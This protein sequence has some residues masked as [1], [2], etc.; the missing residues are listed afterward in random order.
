MYNLW[1]MYIRSS[2][3]NKATNRGLISVYHSRP[4]VHWNLGHVAWDQEPQYKDDVTSRGSEILRIVF[5][6]INHALVVCVIH[7]INPL[8]I[9]YTLEMYCEAIKIFKRYGKTLMFMGRSKIDTIPLP[10]KAMFYIFV[11]WHT[12]QKNN[13]T[14]KQLKQ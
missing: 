5:I 4:S 10:P 3:L 13:T 8:C 14:S 6:S 7:D 12:I 1:Y 9:H 11:F 2:T